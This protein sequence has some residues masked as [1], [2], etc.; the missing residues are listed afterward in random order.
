MTSA[1]NS[2]G[3]VWW[4]ACF[5]LLDSDHGPVRQQGGQRLDGSPKIGRGLAAQDLQDWLRTSPKRSRAVRTSEASA[6]GRS[7]PPPR[8]A[9]A[10]SGS[11]G[12]G[13]GGVVIPTTSVM[14]ISSGPAWSPAPGA[15]PAHRPA[16]RTQ[17]HARRRVRPRTRP[18]ARCPASAAPRRA[19]RGRPTSG[20]RRRPACPTRVRSPPPRPRRPR[21][22]G[23]Y[24]A[25]AMDVTPDAPRPRG[26]WRGASD[27]SAS[28]GPT[29]RHV[30]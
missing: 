19:R 25:Y 1:T 21:T 17:S 6:R 10:R 8:P 15:R 22:R 3:W 26:R 2:A 20:R 18:V 29:T 27:A 12:S 16:A 30:R 23:R 4:A 11:P 9:L 14:N 7:C 24:I 5:A 28:S 13:D